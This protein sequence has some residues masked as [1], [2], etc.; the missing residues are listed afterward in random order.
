M[1]ELFAE[2]CRRNKSIRVAVVDHISS[3]SGIKFPVAKIAKSLHEMGVLVAVDG[4][5]AP[6]QVRGFAIRT[7]I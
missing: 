7:T 6:G 3:P 5:H 2:V 1:V 4:A